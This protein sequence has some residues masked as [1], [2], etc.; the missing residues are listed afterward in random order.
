MTASPRPEPREDHTESAI[1]AFVDHGG[2]VSAAIVE[3]AG[4]LDEVAEA[5]QPQV[6][7]VEQVG[8]AATRIG[9]E[10]EAIAEAATEAR[11]ATGSA[12]EQL[13]ASGARLER[14]TGRVDT[15][16]GGVDRVATS[17]EQSRETIDEVGRVV[18]RIDDIADQTNLLALNATIQAARAGVAGRGFRVVA[19]EVKTLA[20]QTREATQVIQEI[21]GRLTGVL[22]EVIEQ[23]A[24]TQ[25][26]AQDV[27]T[28]TRPLNDAFAHATAALADADAHVVRIDDGV[29][30]VAGS[31][32]ALSDSLD[33]IRADLG[34]AVGSQGRARAE[35]NGLI[36]RSEDLGR[37]FVRA[38]IE[39]PDTPYVA[40]V[41]EA[42]AHVRSVFEAAL[43]RGE[44]SE[45]AL[46]DR[47][48]TPVANS[49]PQQFLTPYTTL[50]DRELLDYQD[51][52]LS[53]LPG[54]VFLGTCDDQG[55]IPTHNKKYSKPQG[56]DPVWNAA[57]CRNRRV[58]D[59]RVG[60]ASGRNRD[61]P[62]VQTYRRDMGGG[63]FVLMKDVSAPITVRGRHWGGVR[64]GYRP[65]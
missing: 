52:L 3:L 2:A 59:D 32:H 58:F 12:R 44:I 35:A 40:L 41:Q 24:E 8:E 55:Y 37:L 54:I 45:A 60:L 13:E 65:A 1:R 21:V 51:G 49:D 7:E 25:R 31:V 53:R 6:Q 22:H 42:A 26:H 56:A 38:G 34:T 15:L 5:L 9:G 18:K 11:A 30:T 20:H 19:E 61:G 46:F 63:E 48:L 33:R 57:N 39:T 17:L 62:L 47:T 36:S 50:C 29:S 27:Q 23:S 64:M 16:I 28:E 10:A 14:A 4:H 43:E